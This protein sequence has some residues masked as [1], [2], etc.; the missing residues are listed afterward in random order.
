MI[1]I[2]LNEI[3]ACYP[4]VD[5]WK[6]VLKSKGGTKADMDAQFPL[7]DILESNDFDDTLW[8]FRCL[9]AHKNLWR[10]YAVWCARQAEHLLTDERSRDALDVAWRHSDGLA[11]DKE[12]KAA[13]SASSDAY[14]DAASAAASAAASGD[15][16]IAAAGAARAARAAMAAAYGAQK[17]KLVEILTAEQWVE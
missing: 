17:E 1:T 3:E 9:P 14:S 7:I 12:L 10:K 5:G 6:K 11:T 4:C 2:S 13:R 15:A 8:C 16:A